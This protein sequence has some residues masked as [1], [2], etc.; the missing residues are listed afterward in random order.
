MSDLKLTFASGP[1]DRM[2]ALTNGAVKIDGVALDH[3]VFWPPR[4]MFDRMGG[5]QAFDAS[6]FSCSEYISQVDRGNCPFVALPVFPSRVF[7]HGFICY[8]RRS[9]IR[10]PK[11]L[12]GKRI[13][14]PLYTQTAAIWIR[15]ILQHDHGVDLSGVHWVQGAVD[16]AGT[17]GEPAAPPMRKPPPIEL[18]KSGRSL[19]ELLADG[20]LDALL[21]T[22]VEKALAV[23][24]DIQRL[25]PDNRAVE[26]DWVRRTGIFPTMH[27]V[28]MRKDVCEKHPWLPERLYRAFNEAKAV[29]MKRYR[30]GTAGQHYMLPWFL[31]DME[32]IE[33]LFGGDPWA[34]GIEANRKTIETLVGYMLEQGFIARRIPMEELFLPVG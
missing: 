15:G 12:A 7:R 9:G 5:Q 21:G 18:N 20:K 25:F 34:Y 8:H 29:A 13:G 10:G 16:D 22:G 27:T 3:K 14:V 6:E 24:P 32:E 1:Y 4:E 23:S 33:A 11:D 26:R 28:V 30:S 19:I 31:N 17:H 2:E